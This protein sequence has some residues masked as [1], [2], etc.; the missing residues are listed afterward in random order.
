[1]P[2]DDFNVGGELGGGSFHTINHSPPASATG[3][4]NKGKT[5]ANEIVAHV[6]DIVLGE[7]DDG[8]AVGVSGRKVKRA[9]V[10][11]VEVNG[12]LV[13]EGNDGESGLF[14]GLVF[15]FHRAPVTRRAAGNQALADVVLGDDRGAGLRQG[16]QIRHPQ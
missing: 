12:N 3:H 9:N 15:H 13:L 16:E 7:K 1:M 10:F 6:H 2:G 11:A 4:I 14:G 8:V 5:V